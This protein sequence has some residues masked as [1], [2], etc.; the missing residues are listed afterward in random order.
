MDL[1]EYSCI[2]KINSFSTMKE[3]NLVYLSSGSVVSALVLM[4]CIAPLFDLHAP[5]VYI[6]SMQFL[7]LIILTVVCWKK[8]PRNLFTFL[9]GAGC[10]IC[11]FFI[12]PSYCLPDHAAAKV[13]AD[14]SKYII[15]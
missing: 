6:E 9:G 12:Y 13:V 10:F 15:M 3:M 7:L 14:Y 1:Q 11:V 5:S 8:W 2:K 4:F